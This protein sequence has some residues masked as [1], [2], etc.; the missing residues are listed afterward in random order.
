MSYI[1]KSQIH[2]LPY[3]PNLFF[4]FCM[5]II[6]IACGNTCRAQEKE[7][8]I[9]VKSMSEIKDGDTVIIAN[10]KMRANGV[11][12]AMGSKYL[13][14][15]KI[16]TCKIKIDGEIATV[17]SD[18]DRIILKQIANSKDVNWLLFSTTH[19][20]YICN[21]SFRK[22]YYNL[23]YGDVNDKNSIKIAKTLISINNTTS[24]DLKDNYAK[25]IYPQ[26]KIDNITYY[27]RAL[28]FSQSSDTI[29]LD[30]IGYFGCYDFRSNDVEGRRIQ[31]YKKLSCLCTL[32]DTVN[33]SKL[34]EANNN[35][36]TPVIL[37]R[38][39]LADTWNTFCVPF[40]IDLKD[41]KINGT[42]VN[43]MEYD[44]TTGH[45]INFKNATK[46]EAGKAYLIKPKKDIKDPV[47]SDVTI[48][49]VTPIVS[50][51]KDGYS[52]VGIYSPITFNDSN[53]DRILILSKEGKFLSVRNGDRMKGMRAY[54]TIPPKTKAE[55]VRL[56]INNKPTAITEIY[57]TLSSPEKIFYTDGTY[58]GTDIKKVK[59]GIVI[60]GGKKILVK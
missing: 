27:E 11:Y 13:N 3:L 47:F 49:N 41:G 4:T 24:I 9:L 14:N 30:H 39:L 52:F 17:S 54:F 32:N 35:K 22:K 12:P 16:N 20:K 15:Y 28:I 2:N 33:N 23:T 48:K 8:F 58:A 5:A 46:I 29:N 44:N 55:A 36:S 53:K 21:N 38:T 6:M 42:E 59:K 10:N 19:Q 57:T 37:S 7:R 18:V 26:T 60:K 56:M 40:D 51:D 34:L 31:L 25:I 43:V 50:G 45:T 1:T